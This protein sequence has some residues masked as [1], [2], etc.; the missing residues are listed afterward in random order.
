MKATATKHPSLEQYGLKDVTVN[1]NLSPEELQ[2][3][4]VDKG[5]GMPGPVPLG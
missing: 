3:I 2:K 1:W 5:M 4:T